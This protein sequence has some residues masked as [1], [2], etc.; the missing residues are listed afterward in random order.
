MKRFLVFAYEQHY[1][2][3]GMGDLQGEF[4]TLEQA[5]AEAKAIKHDWDETEVFDTQTGEVFSY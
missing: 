1:P 5:E 4:D 2:V 3:G